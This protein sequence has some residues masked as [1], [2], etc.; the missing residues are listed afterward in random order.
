MTSLG[1]IGWILY[2]WISKSIIRYRSGMPNDDRNDQVGLETRPIWLHNYWNGVFA[3]EWYTFGNYYKTIM[4]RTTDLVRSYWQCITF[5]ERIAIFRWRILKAFQSEKH[6][7]LTKL[8][9]TDYS[10]CV[11]ITATDLR[12]RLKTLPPHLK[13]IFCSLI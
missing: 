8:H 1:S 7:M 10:S 13:W 5:W 9:F 4:A 2:Y 11:D 3:L 12:W 6:Q